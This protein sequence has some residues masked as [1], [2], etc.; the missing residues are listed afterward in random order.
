MNFL[1][2]PVDIASLV[3]FR[4]VFGILGFADIMGTWTFY[5]LHKGYFN[6]EK[7]QF[8]YIGF[9]WVKPFPE[10]F[11][12]LFF[13]LLMAA[14][15]CIALG[16]W[17]KLSTTIFAIGFTY[18]FLLE[19]SIYLNHGY[20]FCWLSWIMIFLPANRQWSWDVL[21]NPAL[22]SDRIERW[23]LWILPFLMGVV[24]F[25]GGIAKLNA[26]WLDGNPLKIW[27]RS[28]GNMP[29]IGWIWEQEVTA[30]V[31]AW[32]GTLLDLCVPFL[33][34]FR[35]TRTW[36]LVFVIFF[37]LTNMLVFQIGIFPWLSVCLSLLFYPPDFPRHAFSVLKK[38]FN[39][40]EKPEHWWTEK[41][42]NISVTP[43]AVSAAALPPAY[44]SKVVSTLL[45]ILVCF[46]LMMPLRHWYFEGDVAWTEEGHRYAWRMM[47]RQKNGYGYFEI[48]N[49]KTGE[50][51]KIAPEDYLTDRQ[52][53]KLYTHPDMILQFAHYLR[54]LW[55]R[56]GV[57]NAEVYATV[58]ASL[59]GRPT[60]SYIVST[61]DL[62][63][64]EWH[65][66][67]ESSW[68]MPM[69]GQKRD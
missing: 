8:A 3:F 57:Q 42:S 68:I 45:I 21:K 67:K 55:S 62:A 60:Q 7:F 49:P 25:F 65:F 19:K 37:H 30:Y 27:L 40:L 12:S 59:N 24:Y 63:K 51:T 61:V 34:I 54:D 44:P 29:L 10:P 9:E 33:L 69:L 56:R 31:M 36:A 13:F 6:P 23:S 16:R 2:K 20:L 50:V 32:G 47:L 39:K 41:K 4:I 58:R 38:K 46:H 5:H 1:F 43:E 11:M 22:Q 48:K 26:D 53:H 52:T 28:A 15:L 18:T 14:A 35:K 64:E 66:F 17:Y